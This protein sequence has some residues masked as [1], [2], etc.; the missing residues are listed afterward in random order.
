MPILLKSNSVYYWRVFPINSCGDGRSSVTYAF[1]TANKSCV[2]QAYTG[3]PVNLF[4][5]RTYNTI[6]TIPFGGAVA[7]MNVNDI[8]ILW[9][10]PMTLVSA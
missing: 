1:Q 5:S 9:M 2:D 8:D 3:N 7:D 10:L 4:S 6:M